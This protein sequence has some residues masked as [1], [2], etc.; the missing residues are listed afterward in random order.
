MSIV[1]GFPW[2]EPPTTK[3]T[4]N[5]KDQCGVQK[6]PI[7]YVSGPVLFELGLGMAEGGYKY[8]A[9]NYRAM[10]VQASIYFD[11]TMRH[12]W[13]WWEGQDYDPDSTAKL[14]HVTKAI[15]S[16]VV[17]R[18]SML[19]GN[20]TDDRPIRHPS[21]ERAGWLD[22]ANKLIKVLNEQYPKPLQ[23]YT[24]VRKEHDDAAS[25]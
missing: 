15:A 18:D 21:G 3:P 11:A 19:M 9:H 22:S 12:L 8:G 6:A 23:R 10:G 24:Q 2:K 13:A 1:D 20:H 17:I 4:V 14:H 5:P 16:L 25:Q 7:S